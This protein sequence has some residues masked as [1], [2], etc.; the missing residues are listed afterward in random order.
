MLSHADSDHAGGALA[1][2]AAVPVG[3]AISGE[4]E[5]LPRQLA[6][7]ACRNQSWAFDGV[8]FS[9]W[10]WTE[11]RESN[12]RSCVLLI[13]AEGETLLLTG[14]LPLAGEQAWLA[15]HPQPHVD[16]L[17]AGHHGSRSSSGAAFLRALAPTA[18]LI[19]RGRNNPYG[20]PHPQ[21]LQRLSGLGIGVHDT[22]EEGALKILL[23]ARRPL[24]GE[25]ENTRF[26]REK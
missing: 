15:E 3:R 4:P 7:Q 20:H 23:G 2:S 19:S 26:W 17:L 18:V 25:R 13:E 22:A 10:T 1:V 5:R 9:S 14:D 12:E 16:W 11:A 8:H 24:R 6:A 21:V